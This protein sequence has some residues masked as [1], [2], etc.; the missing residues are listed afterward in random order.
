MTT[1][2]RTRICEFKF[3]MVKACADSTD[4]GGFYLSQLSN[5]CKSIPVLV[6]YLDIHAM[7]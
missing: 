6:E 7:Q 4:E 1:S 2:L 5:G 3:I